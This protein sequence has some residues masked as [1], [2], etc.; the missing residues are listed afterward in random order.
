MPAVDAVS[1]AELRAA[2]TGAAHAII[3][4]RN[5]LMVIKL[6]PANRAMALEIIH[7]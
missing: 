3:N 7:P 5:G 6:T 4:G 2:S 1:L